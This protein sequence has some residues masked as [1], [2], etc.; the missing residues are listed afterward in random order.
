MQAFSQMAGG[1]SS[2]GGSGSPGANA[3]SRPGVQTVQRQNA[4]AA[5]TPP[6]ATVRAAQTTDPDERANS[7][8]FGENEV[9]E[10]SSAPSAS[11]VADTADFGIDDSAADAA[12]V[13][14]PDD[15]DTDVGVD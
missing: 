8:D 12:D 3:A 7:L 2:F 13:D 15:P 9:S 14:A 10:A 4:A 11:S 6:G 5:P 1:W